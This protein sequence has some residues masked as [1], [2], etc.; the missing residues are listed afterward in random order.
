MISRGFHSLVRQVRQKLRNTQGFM[1]GEQ[2]IR[3]IFIGLLCIAVGAGLSAALTV[4]SNV[5]QVTESQALLNRAVQEVSDEL[6]YACDVERGSA[7]L[8]FVSNSVHARVTLIDETA[9]DAQGIA[10]QGAGIKS[11][12]P[13]KDETVLLIPSMG[14]F[15]P[16]IKD[17]AYEEASKLWTFTINIVQKD[18]TSNVLATTA[19]TVARIGN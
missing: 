13:T 9:A 12:D 1:L 16:Q 8:S 15:V 17:L 3:V 4:F 18:T 19:M 7:P 5:T 10:L 6:A 11:G 2:L 14:N